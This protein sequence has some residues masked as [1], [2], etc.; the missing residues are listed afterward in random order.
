MFIKYP[1]YVHSGDASHAHG[2]TL[3]D[4]PGCFS[5]ADERVDIPGKVQEAI[6]V[7]CEGE[8]MELPIPSPVKDLR[9]LPEYQGGEWMLVSVNVNI[10]GTGSPIP[11]AS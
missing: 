10:P 9:D 7:Y 6:E 4:F 5:A 1:V 2:I 8:D 11:R 3:P